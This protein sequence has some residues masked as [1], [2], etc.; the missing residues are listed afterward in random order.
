MTE[1]RYKFLRLTDENEIKSESGDCTWRIGEW[2]SEEEV[3]LC[4]T[5][6]HCSQRMYQAFSYVQ[7]EILAQVEVDGVSKIGDDKEAWENMRLTKC[8]QWRKEDSVALSI[9]AAEL[10]IANYE[11]LYPDD[12]RPRKAIEAARK[13]L[14][15]PTEENRS[16]AGSAES[17]AGSDRS[18]Y[19]DDIDD[20]D[21]GMD[22][23]RKD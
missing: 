13:W 23:G 17:A 14:E 16:A 3:I 8:W 21:D 5:G 12:D 22:D 20:S 1:Q 9:F 2:K 18:A 19:A 7:G 11:T 6:F 10:V 4:E 15:A